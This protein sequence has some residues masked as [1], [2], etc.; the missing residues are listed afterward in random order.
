MTTNWTL[1]REKK[2]RNL[3]NQGKTTKHIAKHFGGL[4]TRNAVIGKAHRLGL[5]RRPSPI[6]QKRSYISPKKHPLTVQAEERDAERVKINKTAYGA[7][8]RLVDLMHDECR[9]PV[10]DVFCAGSISKGSY[11]EK[12]SSINYRK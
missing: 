3:W 11:C 10:G 5:P 9:W 6:G 4:F 8:K 2:L 1:Q 12:H 7:G